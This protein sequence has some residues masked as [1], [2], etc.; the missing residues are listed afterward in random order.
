MN[1]IK[2]IVELYVVGYP[3]SHLIFGLQSAIKLSIEEMI[4]YFIPTQIPVRRAPHKIC[5]VN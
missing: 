4:I 3:K 2:K 1:D 5:K